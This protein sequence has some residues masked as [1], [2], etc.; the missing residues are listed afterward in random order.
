MLAHLAEHASRALQPCLSSVFRPRV[1]A[2]LATR[3]PRTRPAVRERH[4]DA[5]LSVAVEDVPE[6]E[7]EVREEEGERLDA[8]TY[9]DYSTQSGKR[10]N[11]RSH[12]FIFY[13]CIPRT[14]G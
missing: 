12:R 3:Q 4:F 2:Q 5:A 7:E 14:G 11:V 10:V 8:H 9:T 1:R 13:S 6:E